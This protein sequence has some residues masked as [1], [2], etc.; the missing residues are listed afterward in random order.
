MSGLGKGGGGSGGLGGLGTKG[1][2]SGGS[3][4]GSGGEAPTRA[5]PTTLHRYPTLEAPGAVRE[6][7]TF[8][9]ELS[10]TEQKRVRDVVVKQGKASADGK[11]ELTLD[12]SDPPWTLDVAIVAPGMD[13]EGSNLAQVQLEVTGDSTPAL[14]QLTPREGTAGQTLEV[15]A[16]FWFK[17]RFLAKVAKPIAVVA[18]GKKLPARAAKPAETQGD[19]A[20]LGD[21][22]GNGPPGQPADLTVWMLEGTDPT[23]PDESQVLIQ[24]P[25]LQPTAGS[26]RQP[27]ELAAVLDR[28]YAELAGRVPRGAAALAEPATETAAPAA[29]DETRA[30]AT[31]LGRALYRDA[32]PPQF[33]QALTALQSA[34]GPR[35]QRIQIYTN[36]PRLP[37]ELLVS[38]ESGDDAQF[39]GA[40]YQLAR[41][42]VSAGDKVLM[43]P[44][45]RLA[46]SGVY[47]VAPQYTGSDALPG[48]EAE[49]KAIAEASGALYQRVDG[50]LAA[51]RQLATAPKEAPAVVHFAGHGQASPHAQGKEPQFVLRLADA[52]LPLSGWR[53][54]AV[55]WG[56]GHPLVFF[57]ACE[58]GRAEHTA[59]L[60]DGWG[61]AVLESGA[62]GYIGGLWPLGDAAASAAATQFYQ[63][64]LD[65]TPVAEA[66]RQLRARFAQTGDPTWL[67][68]V[69]YGDAAL[70]LRQTLQGQSRI[71]L[72]APKVNGP[73][74]ADQ[75]RR[76]LGRHGS[77][78][79]Y[80][81]ERRQ[82]A[83]PN[84]MGRVVLQLV[85]APTGAVIAAQASSNST[86]DE[87]LALCLAQ[88]LR[89]IQFPE[90]TAISTVELVVAVEGK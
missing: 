67:A 40:R 57:N 70:Q 26:F 73:L 22:A 66:V 82:V 72:S 16:T 41:W 65:G 9:L 53:K 24:S 54:L 3:G 13:V 10:L 62:S 81:V 89:R 59:G 61:P 56:G 71:R 88:G 52:P 17:G 80:C 39:L 25:H 64:V 35:L 58:L 31:Q 6:Q 27:A 74:P 20:A 32:A 78:L 21:S 60:V 90:A 4:Y 38:G 28:H 48:Q 30:L 5:A 11:L 2:G 36:S 85:V 23:R 86:G 15:F 50:T 47:V 84:L 43:R 45:P 76:V 55:T 79:R 33:K 49:T 1:M 44:P 68:Y 7:Q 46:L 87:P 63:A 75:V 14:F 34:L 19:G 18:A 8:A 29:A 51:V 12:A 77:R 83:D 42:H 37:W 69:Y